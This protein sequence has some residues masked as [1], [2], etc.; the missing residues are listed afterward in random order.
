MIYQ[1]V[2]LFLQKNMSIKLVN[3]KS[4]CVVKNYVN[5]VEKK[6]CAKILHFKIVHLLYFYVISVCEGQTLMN[7]RRL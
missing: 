5:T 1:C 7:E 4:Q 6:Q 3:V 2:I